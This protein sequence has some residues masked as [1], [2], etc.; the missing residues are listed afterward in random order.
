S[1]LS[2]KRK[3]RLCIARALLGNPQLLFL[4]ESTNSL[5]SVS[6]GLVQK[7]IDQLGGS[8]SPTVIAV[9]HWLAA[10]QRDD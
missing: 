5:D 1:S 9:A 3:Q 10:M 4:N 2:G 7:A 6:K 8:R